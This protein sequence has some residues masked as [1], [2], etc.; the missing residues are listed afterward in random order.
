MAANDTKRI[1]VIKN[2]KSNLIEEAIFILRREPKGE[3]D[4]I[5]KEAQAIIDRYIKENGLAV[6]SGKEKAKGRRGF[7][8]VFTVNYVINILLI[9]SFVI[10]LFLLAQLILL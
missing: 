9:S 4:F 6:T 10:L 8:S 3:G 2:I 1:V 5:L 7:N